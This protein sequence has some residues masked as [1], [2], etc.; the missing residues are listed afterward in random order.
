MTKEVRQRIDAIFRPN[1]PKRQKLLAGMRQRAKEMDE[2]FFAKARRQAQVRAL[3]APSLN[4][5]RQQLEMDAKT[6]KKLMTL[7]PVRPRK[8]PPLKIPKQTDRIFSGSVGA[9]LVPPYD[10][11]WTWSQQQGEN[12]GNPQTS[13]DANS[14]TMAITN[15]TTGQTASASTAVGIW[16]IPPLGG[17][18]T[19][20]ISAAPAFSWAW[21]VDAIFN[22]SESDGWINVVVE[23]FDRH[24]GVFIANAVDQPFDLWDVWHS[25]LGWGSDD[26]T[27]TGYPVQVTFNT[28]EGVY[29]TVWIQFS[30]YAQ[31]GDMALADFSSITV[32]SITWAN[33]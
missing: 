28:T 27:T 33:T 6:L 1:P 4:K 18:S 20:T 13:A 31:S 15:I 17:G 12:P 14:G 11:D 22:Y 29:Y 19:M 30:T 5:L 10:V 8:R 24:S 23:S 26:Y 9:T 16:L 21:Y 25:F 7:R 32:P 3:L 2:R